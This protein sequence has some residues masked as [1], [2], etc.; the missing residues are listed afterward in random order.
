MAKQGVALKVAH[1]IE[2]GGKDMEFYVTADSKVFGRVKIS[3]GAI[4]WFPR[5]AQKG[6]YE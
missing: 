4:D 1:E 5:Y 2:I 3:R 6:G